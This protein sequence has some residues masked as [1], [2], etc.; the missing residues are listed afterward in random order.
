MTAKEYLSEVQRLKTIIE[1]KRE[2]I[3][4]IREDASTVR[5]VRSDLDKVSG[6][7]YTDRIGEAVAKISELET[8]IENDI[9]TLV[10]LKHDI[11]NQ[12]QE[13]EN[14]NYADILYKHYIKGE[15]L[16]K[17]A[18]EMDL[19]YQYVIVLHGKA[20]KDFEKQH[21]DILQKEGISA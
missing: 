2:Q 10:F 18:Y 12:I 13:I 9:L 17:I 21:K 1:R 20:L 6:S 15:S 4:E 19:T 5:A 7:G 3:K 14:H 8:E 11:I 16:A